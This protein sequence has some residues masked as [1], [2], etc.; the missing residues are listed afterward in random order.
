MKH[1]TMTELKQIE[2]NEFFADM[3]SIA[4]LQRLSAPPLHYGT[5]MNAIN[6]Q[7]LVCRKFGGD[8]DGNGVWLI[9]L[10]SAK[11]IWPERFTGGK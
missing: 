9:S 11:H 4:E 6:K 5:I 3:K 10:Q 2:V 8:I 1:L 7:K